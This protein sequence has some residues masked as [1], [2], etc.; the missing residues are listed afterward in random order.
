M[1]VQAFVAFRAWSSGFGALGFGFRIVIDS[2]E[3]ALCT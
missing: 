1:K 3:H 2:G